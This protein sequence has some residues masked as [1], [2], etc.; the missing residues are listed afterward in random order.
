MVAKIT[1][2]GL[3]EMMGCIYKDEWGNDF[4]NKKPW[5]SFFLDEGEFNKIK[6]AFLH[7]Q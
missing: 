5:E 1:S 6:I 3:C 7:D 2:E 4:D